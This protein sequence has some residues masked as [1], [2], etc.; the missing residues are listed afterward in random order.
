[1]KNIIFLL[2]LM[3]SFW[4]C[5]E[6]THEV[7]L[8]KHCLSKAESFNNINDAHEIDRAYVVLHDNMLEVTFSRGAAGPFE[9]QSLQYKPI[10]YCVATKDFSVKLLA[11]NLRVLYINELPE[12][13][14]FKNEDV[15][16]TESLYI[17]G[18]DGGFYFKE[19]R[20]VGGDK[21]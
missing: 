1:M 15:T 11:K 7:K 6:E 9:Q 16:E 3:P 4:G 10:L 8:I 18:K 12:L 20:A 2:L 19:S 5:A 13:Y 21:F 17:K 14:E